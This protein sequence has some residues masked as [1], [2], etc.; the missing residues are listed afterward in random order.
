[1]MFHKYRRHLVHQEAFF[2]WPFARS[3]GVAWIWVG[4]VSSGESFESHP[5]GEERHGCS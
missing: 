2:S 3:V 4:V 1:M 5:C